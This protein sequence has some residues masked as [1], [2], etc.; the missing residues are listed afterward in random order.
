MKKLFELHQ[1]IKLMVNEYRIL[2]DE[3]AGGHKLRGFARQKRL[4]VREKFTLYADENQ[5]QILATSKA[6]SIMELGVIFD[7]SDEAGK[8]LAVMKKEFKRSLISSTWS[9]YSPDMKAVLYTVQEKSLAMAIGRRLWEILPVPLE[10][11][12]P[13][14]FHFLILSGGQEVGEHIKTTLFRDR[15]AFYL[16]EEHIDKLDIRVWMIAAVLLDAMQSR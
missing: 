6:R 13:L 2:Q 7:I 10:L 11:P 1:N 15:Y 8:P 12:L 14:K 16:Q 5:K 9:I 4:A 3:A